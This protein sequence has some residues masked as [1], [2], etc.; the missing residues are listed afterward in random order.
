[1]LKYKKIKGNLVHKTAVINWSNLVIG[2][3]NKIG[4]YVIIGNDPQHPKSKSNGKIF[5]GN[6]N[7]FNEFCNIHLPTKIK[8]KTIIGDNNYFMNSSTIDHDCII[9]D[10]VILSSNT[11]LGGNVIIM[12]NSQLGIG[13][14]VHQNQIIGS[15]V[16]IGMKSII[17]KKL[18]V[19]PGYLY[20]G[21]P[22]KMIKKNLVGIKR[23]KITEEIL[24][25]EYKRFLDLKR[26]KNE[27]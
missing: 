2:K 9:E 7:T 12:K 22:A 26:K 20:Y 21:K 5:I 4:P 27:K 23:N 8:K 14:T 6:G 18:K 15:Y 16:M 25:K 3:G 1:M 24:K 11:I 17:T 13:V 19:K 10:N